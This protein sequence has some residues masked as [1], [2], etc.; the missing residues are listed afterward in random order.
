MGVGLPV[1]AWSGAKSSKCGPELCVMKVAPGSGRQATALLCW[2]CSSLEYNL[3]N[4][5]QFCIE[6]M[7]CKLGWKEY[8]P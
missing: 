3:A 7:E 4:A 6:T 1:V 8:L 2:V 5:I